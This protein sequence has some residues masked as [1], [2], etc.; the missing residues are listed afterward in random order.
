MKDKLNKMIQDVMGVMPD[1]INII[2]YTIPMETQLS[3]FEISKKVKENVSYEVV[4]QNSNWLFKDDVSNED[5]KWL[6]AQLASIDKPE[7]YRIIEKYVNQASGE[8]LD[9]ARIALIESRT[10]LESEL[11]NEN[12]IIISSGL[13]GE[14]NMLRYF[15]VFSK[16][17]EIPF[18]EAQCKLIEIE[19]Q[20]AIEKIK[21]A[22]EEITFHPLYASILILVPFQMDVRSVLTGII[23]TCNQYGSFLNVKF[24]ITN[25]KK[26]THN[27]I[28]HFLNKSDNNESKEE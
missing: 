5:K 9:W 11:L 24:I 23:Q 17:D 4:L 3:Y 28:I 1:K 13:G 16:N 8:M 6:L 26:L 15:I 7:A 14:D 10:L 12:Q 18:S 2:P 19:T 27:E 20:E 21:G 25:V 22:V